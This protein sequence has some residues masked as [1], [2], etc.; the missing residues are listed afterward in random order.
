MTCI[1]KLVSPGNARFSSAM[2]KASIASPRESMLSARVQFSLELHSTGKR[3]R[4]KDCCAVSRFGLHLEVP[5]HIMRNGRMR[6]Q[7]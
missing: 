7:I 3:P 6:G 5:M 4:C 1:S 2:M